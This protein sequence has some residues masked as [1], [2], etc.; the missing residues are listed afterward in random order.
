MSVEGRTTPIRSTVAVRPDRREA[1]GL[2]LPSL[3]V[4]LDGS[5]PALARL[6]QTCMM[7]YFCPK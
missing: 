1:F 4:A 5:L 7:C 2:P 3:S 6:L